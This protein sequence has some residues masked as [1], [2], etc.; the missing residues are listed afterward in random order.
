MAFWK[1][2]GVLAIST[3]LA[4][5]PKKVLAAVLT[6]SAFISPCLTI[7]LAYPMSE[8]CFSTGRDSPV[9]ADSSVKR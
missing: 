4:V 3:S 5:L 1:W 7:E 8:R 2:L 9:S 6:T